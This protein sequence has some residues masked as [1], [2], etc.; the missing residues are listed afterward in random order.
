MYKK[1]KGHWESDEKGQDKV[2]PVT[3]VKLGWS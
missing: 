1:R 3:L 2:L